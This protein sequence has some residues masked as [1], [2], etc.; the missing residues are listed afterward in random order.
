VILGVHT[1]EFAFEREPS[2]VSRAVRDLGLRYPVALDSDYGTW[3][4]WGNRY[5][6]AKYFVDRRGHVR[7]GHF[8]EGDYA[9][10]EQVIRQLLAE[11]G[12]MPAQTAQVAHA[13]AAS[14]AAITPETYLGYERLNREQQ[15]VGIEPKPDVV[16][17]YRFPETL[18]PSQFAYAGRWRVEAERIVARGRDARLRLRF[19]ARDVHLVLG[20]RGAVSVRLNGTPVRTVRVTEDRLYTLLRLPKPSEGLLELRFSPGVQAYAFTFG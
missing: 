15:Y 17:R 9:H 13:D 11:G 3:N 5:W 2:N 4:A 14:S 8:G 6:P 10:S 12:S 18:G 7:Y 1:P 20:G 16:A 19:R